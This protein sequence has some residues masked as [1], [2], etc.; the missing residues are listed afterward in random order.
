MLKISPKFKMVYL[1][2]TTE[3]NLNCD[4]CYVIDKN[5][6]KDLTTK[7]WMEIIDN[8]HKH[9]TEIVQI[10]GG[11]PLLRKDIFD[12]LSRCN[13][14]FK[15]VVLAT[16]IT[17][18]TDKEIEVFKKYN[19]TIIYCSLNNY[20][21]K[22]LD[23]K[24]KKIF[25]TKISNLKKL[26]KNNVNVLI[27]T[28][29][30]DSNF[31]DLLRIKEFVEEIDADWK[32]GHIALWGK[33]KREMLDPITE[34]SINEIR[35]KISTEDK[36]IQVKPKCSAG[37]SLCAIME[38]GDVTPCVQS[39]EKK[40]VGGN[41][42]KDDLKKIYNSSAFKNWREKICVTNKKCKNCI[43]FKECKGGCPMRRLGFSNTFKDGLMFDY[44]SC[45]WYHYIKEIGMENDFKKKMII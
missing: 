24:E 31:N 23:E 44:S 10:T 9:G 45:S 2:V 16:N 29:I 42:L 41:I 8:L 13:E 5:P 40:Y 35:K 17:L 43:F 38:N 12:I 21:E 3:C 28:M 37:F 6:K 39:R 27:S 11:E 19:N 25:K 34:K 26:K 22:K 15:K 4:Y 7:Q 20:N 14:K 32:I 33:A 1:T 36:I 18:I 30:S